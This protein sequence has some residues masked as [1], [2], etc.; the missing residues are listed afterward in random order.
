MGGK[1]ELQI[2]AERD[3]VFLWGWDVRFKWGKE[4]DTGL[5]FLRDLIN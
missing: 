1:R 3:F 5:Q 4:R 2:V